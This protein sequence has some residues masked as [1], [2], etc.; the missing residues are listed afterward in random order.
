MEHFNWEPPDHIIV[1]GGNL[2]NSSA[3][4][5]AFQE[6]K[7]LGLITH[8]PK[9]SI[10]QAEGANPLVRTIRE[11]DGK[12]LVSV[13]AETMATAIRIGSPASW[14]KALRISRCDRR[15]SRASDGSRDRTGQS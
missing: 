11:K 5:K 14:K 9:I 1:P 3:L 6:M 10:I 15:D 2:G 4:G 7:D 13:Q 8:F 12:E